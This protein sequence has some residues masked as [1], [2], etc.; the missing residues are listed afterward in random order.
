[1]QDADTCDDV[2]KICSDVV[3]CCGGCNFEITL[4]LAACTPDGEGEV[5]GTCDI[6]SCEE[7]ATMST[8]EEGGLCSEAIKA[9]T[10]CVAKT[11]PD[12]EECRNFKDGDTCED[13]QAICSDVVSCCGG[14]NI[15][16]TA[17]LAACT[18]G[19]GG[20][21]DI[22]TC[23]EEAEASEDSGALNTKFQPFS[24]LLSAVAFGAAGLM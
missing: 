5:G 10:K 20:T 2:K 8:A 17:L 6:T 19:E 7:E 21:C 11:C 1:M 15:E 18:P 23:Q 13:V 12:K 14:C 16:T 22:S 4:L 3:S 24:V 9:I